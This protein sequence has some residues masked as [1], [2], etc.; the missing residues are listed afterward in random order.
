M[1]QGGYNSK[2]EFAYSFS[3]KENAKGEC[4]IEKLTIKSDEIS[5]LELMLA[6]YYKKIKQALIKKGARVVNPPDD[7][8]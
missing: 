7:K 8:D 4:Y 3:I 6:D 2:S 1:S 5:G